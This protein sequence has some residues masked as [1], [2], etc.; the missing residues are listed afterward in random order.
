[1]GG[2][3]ER[4]SGPLP[5][6]PLA[7]AHPEQQ[8]YGLI[9]SPADAHLAQLLQLQSRT[10]IRG[11][12]TH[13]HASREVAGVPSRNQYSPYMMNAIPSCSTIGVHGI[14]RCN[15]DPSSR[16]SRA[17]CHSIAAQGVPRRASERKH[18]RKCAPNSDRQGDK[19]D[20]PT[21]AVFFYLWCWSGGG[22]Q[23]VRS[24]LESCFRAPSG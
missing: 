20:R 18:W 21:W 8:Q 5:A 2:A 6:D 13:Q 3:A 7:R 4:S 19:I 14:C 12:W 23:L 10:T 17:F 1:V 15:R 24:V 22:C 16:S 9:F 11:R